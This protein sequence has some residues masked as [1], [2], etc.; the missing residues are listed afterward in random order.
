MSHLLH[1][2]AQGLVAASPQELFEHLDDPLHLARHME[3]RSMAMMGS[4]MRI[5]TD[6]QRGRVVGSLIRMH[7]RMMG[8]PLELEEIVIERDP[9]RGKAWQTIGEPRLVVIGP[10]RMG[11]TIEPAS[12]GGLLTVWIDYQL[13]ASRLGRWLGRPLAPLYA[14][15]C[16]QRMLGWNA[17]P[18]SV[19]MT[20]VRTRSSA[21]SWLWVSSTTV[22]TQVASPAATVLAVI[23]TVSGK[24][25]LQP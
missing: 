25:M 1:A 19:R 5:D 8:I 3:R 18:S 17:R 13:P 14:R 7:G 16:C 21:R 6:A 4:S 24:Q 22:K 11:F 9:P 2:A 15:W 12:A 10:Y 20:T 23:L